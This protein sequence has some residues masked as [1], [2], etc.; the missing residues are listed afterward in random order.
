MKCPSHA[1]QSLTS[2]Q[3]LGLGSNL[4]SGATNKLDMFVW[5]LNLS[6]VVIDDGSEEISML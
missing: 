6:S 5:A 2:F 1:C 3:F 4:E